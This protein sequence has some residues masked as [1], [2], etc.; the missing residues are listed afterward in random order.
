MSED[1]DK[2]QER[3]RV[4]E[5]RIEYAAEQL[6]CLGNELIHRLHGCPYP[7]IDLNDLQ[8]VID[9]LEYDFDK[10]KVK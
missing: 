3:I 7:E 10:R 2:L 4:L 1:I 5:Q 8:E 6:H 9:M